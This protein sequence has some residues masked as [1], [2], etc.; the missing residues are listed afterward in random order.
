[1]IL[2]SVGVVKGFLWFADSGVKPGTWPVGRGHWQ[3]RRA[4]LGSAPGAIESPVP[5][6]EPDPEPDPDPD[7][8]P[9]PEPEPEPAP[10]PDPAP[11]P[12][13]PVRARGTRRRAETG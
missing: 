8:E 1:M 4:G 9:E 10:D 6:P 5:V 13:P 7:P 2:G 3:D 11:A 12:V